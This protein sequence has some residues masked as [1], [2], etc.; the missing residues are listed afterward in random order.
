L[1]INN[2]LDYYCKYFFYLI[3]VYG[4]LIRI[5][6]Y[7]HDRS[8]WLD[9]ARVGLAVVE[10]TFNQQLTTSNITSEPIGFMVLAKIITYAIGD[11]DIVLRLP[12]VLSGFI[13]LVLFILIINKLMDN[14]LDKIISASLFIFSF[15]LIYY[16][17]EFKHYMLD[18]M[19]S[20][21]FLYLMLCIIENNQFKFK[22]IIFYGAVGACAVWLSYSS[23]FI[24]FSLSIF[25]LLF[26]T[27]FNLN[28]KSIWNFLL[29]NILIVSSFL[30][31]YFFKLKHLGR[32]EHLQSYWKEEFIIFP[33]LSVDI[34]SKNVELF[35]DL[36]KKSLG[37]EIPL[38]G[39]LL[40]LLFI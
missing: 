8:F 23:I 37:I 17:S 24:L 34:L 39:F 2:R 25:L 19:F 4:V 1:N 22:D 9:E 27:K 29:S 14:Y 13:S 31:Y 30:I 35:I 26:F 15:P 21:Y 28:I 7:L 3:I 18:V 32:N 38:I 16:S 10:R 12:V 36:F 20:V 6:Q 11:T 40:F 33:S 5:V